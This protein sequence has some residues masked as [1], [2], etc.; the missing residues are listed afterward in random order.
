MTQVQVNEEQ[1]KI[2]LMD[3]SYGTDATPFLINKREGGYTWR[4]LQEV[5]NEIASKEDKMF[6]FIEKSARYKSKDKRDTFQ[7][8]EE[9]KLPEKDGYIMMAPTK[10]SSGSRYRDLVT[11]ISR[12]RGELGI[13]DSFNPIGKTTDELKEYLDTLNSTVTDPEEVDGVIER[14]KS[15]YQMGQLL[16]NH[17]ADY[18]S[19]LG[20]KVESI[21]GNL[22]RA[23]EE[24]AEYLEGKAA[25]MSEQA[26]S[27]RG[28]I[29]SLSLEEQREAQEFFNSLKGQ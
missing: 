29:V 13:K 20:G 24:Q 12:K 18:F 21:E 14:A 6:N 26:S 2:L 17:A 15:L 7:L 22:K 9:T 4:E 10:M 1:F 27:L 11:E 23:L 16:G 28:K 3:T 19:E 25:E 8:L 5:I